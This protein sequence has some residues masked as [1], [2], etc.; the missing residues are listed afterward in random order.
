MAI[1]LDNKLAEA[2]VAF[3]LAN[4][5]IDEYD[6]SEKAFKNALFYHQEVFEW[7][8]GLELVI[9]VDR[10]VFHILTCV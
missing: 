2:H 5:I 10:D 7:S 4:S 1:K 9:L 8:V 3:G 6:K